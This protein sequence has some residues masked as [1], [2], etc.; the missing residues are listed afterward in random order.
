MINGVS[1]TEIRAVEQTHLAHFRRLKAILTEP[2]APQQD[3][4]M[5]QVVR[6]RKNNHVC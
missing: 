1:L 4:E 2:L 3:Q 5:V 6:K